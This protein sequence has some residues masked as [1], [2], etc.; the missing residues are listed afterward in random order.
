MARVVDREVDEVVGDVLHV[1]EG[2]PDALA[3]LPITRER[4]AHVP[5]VV[6]ALP[7]DLKHRA[8]RHH[9]PHAAR[10]LVKEL[11]PDGLVLHAEEG[12]R[13]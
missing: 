9:H 7:H 11:L 13:A 6:H 2:I 4:M 1:Q 10:E 12:A 5:V 3:D 8:P